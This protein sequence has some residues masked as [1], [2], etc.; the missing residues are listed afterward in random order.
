MAPEP[1]WP[2]GATLGEGPV[3]VAREAALWFVDIKAPAIHRFDP[4]TGEQAWA[5]PAQVG[6]VLPIARGGM[7]AGLQSGVHRFDPATGRSRCWSRQRRAAGQPPERC[8]GCGRWRDLA[9]FDGRCR[10]ADTGAS[11]A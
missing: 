4:A 1:V 3:W 5:A 6:W 7:I 9:R 11:I 8:D 10:A 2:L